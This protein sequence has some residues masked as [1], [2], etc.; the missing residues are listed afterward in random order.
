MKDCRR[1]FVERIYDSRSLS[2]L[3]WLCDM[4]DASFDWDCQLL[5]SALVVI[6]NQYENDRIIVVSKSE[7]FD[8]VL[9]SFDS[10]CDSLSILFEIDFANDLTKNSTRAA[11]LFA[12]ECFVLSEAFTTRLFLTIDCLLILS[13]ALVFFLSFD[14]I[15]TMTSFELDD[16][17]MML[18]E[19]VTIRWFEIYNAM[20]FSK[21]NAIVS[22]VEKWEKV[23]I[24]ENRKTR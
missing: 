13:L 24:R 18:F 2:Y 1:D 12:T 21:E 11:N 20:I 6:C 5:W 7:F 3:F 8:F 4:F 19:S 22:N 16:F 17:V 10:D 9:N 23:T 15:L 14:N